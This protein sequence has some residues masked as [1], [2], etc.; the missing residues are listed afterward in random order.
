MLA[1]K[2]VS[3]YDILG[4]WTVLQEMQPADG[5]S[6]STITVPVVFYLAANQT[7]ISMFQ[8]KE[9][10]SKYQFQERAWPRSVYVMYYRILL[11]WM[12]SIL[13]HSQYKMVPYHECFYLSFFTSELN[14]FFVCRYCTFQFDACAFKGTRDKEAVQMTYKGYFKKSILNPRILHMR[15]SIHKAYGNFL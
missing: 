12:T 6:P 5:S 2:H 4:T 9:Y 10:R 14:C 3:P 11:P 15:G 1:G 8:G 13:C 7:L